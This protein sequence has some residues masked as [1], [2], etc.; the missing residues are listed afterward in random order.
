MDDTSLFGDAAAVI[1]G[2]QKVG[3]WARRVASEWA[4][5][6][7][8]GRVMLSAPSHSAGGRSGSRTPMH[9]VQAWG[10]APAI[11]VAGDGG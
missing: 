5:R 6:C 9:R 10:G 8:K 1:G 11:T 3:S 2:K 7:T 4:I